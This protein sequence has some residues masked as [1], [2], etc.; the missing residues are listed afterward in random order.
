[1]RLFSAVSVVA[2][3]FVS[4]SSQASVIIPKAPDL[5][6]SAYILMDATNGQV[7]VEHNVEERLPPASLT[8][9]L[10]SYIAIHELDLG[11]VAE[12][13]PV[14]IS[15]KAWRMGGSKMF[16]RE[17][18]EVPLIDLL[19]GIIVQS[20]NDASL[21]VA[22]YF[23]GAEEEFAALMNSFAERFGMHDSHFVN[24]TGWPA[25]NHYSTARDMATLALHIIND[26]P[27]YYPL[28]A[29]KYYE[30][31]NIRQPNRNRLLW[32]DPSVDGLKT[33]H[34]DEAGYGLVASAKRDDTRFIAV[35]MGARSDESRARETQKLLSYGFRYF[36]SRKI[37]QAQEVL[38]TAKVWM[39]KEESIDL[40]LAKDLFLTLPR[41]SKG[42]LKVNIRTD[43]VLKAPIKKGQALGTLTITRDGE[44]LTEQPLL[45]QS[46]I[47]E[48]GFFSRLIDKIK[49]FFIQ[50][51]A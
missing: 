11:H 37:Y 3:L 38:S 24:S 45:A 15:V 5:D 46:D 32:R 4:L 16:V 6:A 34:T 12:D 42:E 48:A 40:G 49:L 30:Y 31:N 14:P 17:G 22:E 41:G 28:Y 19:R 36:E 23:S 35:V 29:E 13:T 20:G 18:T 21:A 44:L 27:Q 51:F 10:T 2:L 43:E 7:L 26:H 9:M 39:G 25:E 1:M 33:G 50:L 8:K 47:E